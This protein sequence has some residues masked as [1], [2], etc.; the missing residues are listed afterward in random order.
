MFPPK[1][2]ISCPPMTSRVTV[3]RAKHSPAT[4]AISGEIGRSD[5]ACKVARTLVKQKMGL[6]G[7][8]RRALVESEGSDWVVEAEWRLKRGEMS[9][10]RGGEQRRSG[11]V[12]QRDPVE[13]PRWERRSRAKPRVSA[14]KAA[15]DRRRR[16]GCWATPRTP[17]RATGRRR[18]AC[19]RRG[20]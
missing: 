18:R 9:E 16:A 11:R 4:G 7:A 2:A 3:L 13:R 8:F 10:V 15:A 1:Y 17:P 6:R 14:E 12:A 5:T 20:W 19:G